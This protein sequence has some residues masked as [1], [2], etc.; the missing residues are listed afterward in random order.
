MLTKNM[1]SCITSG[2]LPP[3]TPRC[4]RHCARLFSWQQ[5]DAVEVAAQLSLAQ[6]QYALPLALP[7]P[8]NGLS[9]SLSAC[10][11]II[12]L[13]KHLKMMDENY[14]ILQR[15]QIRRNYLRMINALRRC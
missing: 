9:V 8:S 12:I 3:Q 5:A 2:L 7:D 11:T 4:L 10:L 15:R 1:K 6:A 14:R 13:R